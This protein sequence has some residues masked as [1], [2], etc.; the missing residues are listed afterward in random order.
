MMAKHGCSW[1]GTLVREWEIRLEAYLPISRQDT[2]SP[3]Q[4]TASTPLC[5]LEKQGCLWLPSVLST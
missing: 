2:Q 3:S 5:S 4:Q 1:V